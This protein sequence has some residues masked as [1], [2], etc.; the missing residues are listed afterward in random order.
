MSEYVEMSVG[1]AKEGSNPT[2]Q[3]Y[4]ISEKTTRQ[5]SPSYYSF[6][7]GKTG[8]LKLN[9]CRKNVIKS[10]TMHSSRVEE[11]NEGVEVCE[12]QDGYL[13]MTCGGKQV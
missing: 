11:G 9:S 4:A 1:T 6:D 12:A 10:T 7:R 13:D 5:D 2:S 8:K 3:S